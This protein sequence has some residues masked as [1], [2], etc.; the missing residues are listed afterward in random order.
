MGINIEKHGNQINLVGDLVADNLVDA[1]KTIKQHI[2]T[3]DAAQKIEISLQGL[4]QNNSICLS[5]ILC[6]LRY[7]EQINRKIRFT[8]F[9]TELNNL[10]EVYNLTK[11]IKDQKNI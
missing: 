6:C 10:V 7:A 4:T 3:N 5:F 2:V 9:S 11:I 1:L 8:S